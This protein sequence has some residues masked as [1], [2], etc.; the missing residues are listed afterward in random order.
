M[1]GLRNRLWLWSLAVCL[2]V[3]A[4]IVSWHGGSLSSGLLLAQ[5][6]VD[7]LRQSNVSLHMTKMIYGSGMQ[8]NAE[9]YANGNGIELL[10]G[11]GCGSGVIVDKDG[12]I[13]T[14]YHVAVRMMQASAVWDNGQ[15]YEVRFVKALDPDDDLAILK[16]GGDGNFTPVKLGNSD[17]VKELDE[18]VAAGNGWCQG[19]ALTNGTINQII[20]DR[21]GAPIQLRHSAQILRGNSGGAL[22]RDNEVI[23]INYLSYETVDVHYA[24]PVNTA[25]VLLSKTNGA[26]LRTLSEQFPPNL[27]SIFARAELIDGWTA[28]LAPVSAGETSIVGLV[29]QFEMLTD[30]C[31]SVEVGNEADVRLK[32]HDGQQ[33]IGFSDMNYAG[34]EIIFIASEMPQQVGCVVENT[35]EIATNIG[36]KLYRIRW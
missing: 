16:I 1:I 14:N 2:V 30:Y 17:K 24:I 25:K 18:V 4:P 7:K 32:L 19:L 3:A 20:K 36:L 9:G 33:F 5:T 35:S 10:Q 26:E 13:I 27:D 8:S 15:M 11:S 22:Y 23:G 31:I 21:Y 12:T 28:T 6:D 34:P 29:L